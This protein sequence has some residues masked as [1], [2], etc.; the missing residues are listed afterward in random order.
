MLRLQSIQLYQFKNYAQRQFQ[1]KARLV[2]ICGKNGAGKTNLLDAIY[3]L[4][5][6][7]SY[8]NKSDVLNVLQGA[9]GFRI[10]GHFDL[11]D[12]PVQLACILRETGKKEFYCDEVLYPRLSLHI[13]RFPAVMISPDDVALITEGAEIRRRFL[14]SL[15]SQL[16]PQYLRQ[17]I[18]YNRVLQQRNSYLKQLAESGQNGNSLLDVYDKQLAAHGTAIFEIRQERLRSLIPVILDRYQQIAEG[19][20]L[21]QLRYLS[22]LHTLDLASLLLQSRERDRQA[23]RTLT[24]VHRDDLEINMGEQPFKTMASQGQRKSL[25]FALKLAEFETL[26]ANMG[27]APLLLLDDVFEKLDESRMHNLLNQVCRFNT[28]QVFI[29]DT[30]RQRFQAEMEKLQLDYEIIDL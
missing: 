1:F 3:Y 27:F 25:L 19:N 23:Q 18:D 5:F 26:Q 9:Q 22:Q 11:Q 12:T 4:C 6:T 10:A 17:L 14:D 28:G 24:G 20:D 21:P 13:G 30:H 16:D 2:G 7:R 29:T 8:F 15:L